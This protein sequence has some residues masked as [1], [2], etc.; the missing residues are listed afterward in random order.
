MSP[1]LPSRSILWTESGPSTNALFGLPACKRSMRETCDIR[2]VITSLVP[3]QLHVGHL[4]MWIHQ[5]LRD[6]LRAESGH[7]GDRRKAGN[8]SAPRF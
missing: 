6:V 7:F 3:R 2:A 8:A 1:S 4:G 5:D